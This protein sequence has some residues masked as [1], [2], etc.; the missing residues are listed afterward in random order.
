MSVIQVKTWYYSDPDRAGAAVGEPMQAADITPRKLPSQARSRATF[1][2]IVEAGAW[3]LCERG[4]HGTTTNH[5]AERAGVNISSLYEY[6]PGKD[7]IVA[8]VAERLVER[9]LQRLEAGLPS[10]EAAAPDDAVRLWITLIHRTVA[11][12]RALVRV[13]REQVPYTDRLPAVQALG[14][15]LLQFSQHIQR[16]AGDFVHPDFNPATLHLVVNLVTSTIL[17]LVLDPPRGIT[18]KALLAE[19]ARRVDGWIRG[20]T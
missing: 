7:A 2:A 18:Q 9:V 3:V 20:E 14:P 4:F 6:F 12:E 19:L 8:L 16:D 10:I 15:R 13:F 5:V 1:E 11:H 17:Q